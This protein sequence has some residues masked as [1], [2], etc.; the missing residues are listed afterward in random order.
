MNILY[1]STIVP[2]PLDDGDRQRSYHLLEA[3]AEKHRVH[4]LC[5]LRGPHEAAPLKALA[6]L[7]ASTQ[8]IPISQA[9]IYA[10]SLGAVL[11]SRALNV[12]SFHSAAMA[13]AVR[14]AVVQRRI[15]VLHAYRLRM[16]PFALAV[17]VRRRV[18]DYTD[19]L[20][21]QFANRLEA[22]PRAWQR[23]YWQGEA[24]KLAQYEVEVSRRFD[25]CLISSAADRDYL[26]TLGARPMAEVTNGVD[27]QAVRP[28]RRL[29]A[30]P[31]LLFVGNLEYPPNHWGMQ[32]FC[33][34]TWPL[35]RT[36]APQARLTVAGRKPRDFSRN[37]AYHQ[38]GLEFLGV[39]PDLAPHFRASRVAICPVH[40]ASGRQFKV[41]EYFAAGLPTVT[42][43]RVAENAHAR[44]GRECLT[45]DTPEAFARQVVHL[46]ADDRLAARL[47]TAARRLV[48]AQ[49]DWRHAAASLHA[50][51]RA[52][53]GG[54]A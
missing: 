2:F 10:N 9:Q 37:P 24:K 5:F 39:V 33:R 23:W 13:A 53:S 26:R 52:L 54:H 22:H 28:A 49:Y 30:E 12:A 45:A 47:R 32:E 38:P 6:R 3:L 21:R 46:L 20:A 43:P 41:L 50:V 51:Y 27:T 17:Q 42:T 25:A 44:P 15:D 11:G 4:L 48:L 36:Q 7:C 18:L 14:Q 16:A 29:P 8:G 19:S 40:V 34:H 1:L 35:I 31:R